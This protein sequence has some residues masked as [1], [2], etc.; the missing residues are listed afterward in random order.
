MS[1]KK[2]SLIK[3][4]ILGDAGVGKTSLLKKYVNNQ[5]SLQYKP[6][7]GADFL[8]K[9]TFIDN[10]AIQLQLWDTA[11]QEK[12]HSLG[13][14]FYRNSEC[15]V[16]V[17]DLTDP[18]SFETIETWR[19]EFLTQLN[20]KDPES[21]PFIL[22]GNKCDLENNIKV[23]DQKVKAYCAQKN[24]M[25]YFKTSAKDNVNIELAFEEVG[26]LA[27]KRDTNDEM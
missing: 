15:C 12:F 24:N 1:S 25:A 21:F 5:Y 4:I 19:S 23:D 10:Q 26:K 2:R 14:A 9:E 18:K 11:G 7:I 16:L 22:L 17:F 3:V 13:S 20:P 27:N 6:T 8:M